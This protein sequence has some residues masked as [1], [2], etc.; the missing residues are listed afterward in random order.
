MLALFNEHNTWLGLQDFKGP[1]RFYGTVLMGAMTTTERQ[2][3]GTVAEG[4]IVYD[5]TLKVVMVYTGT[6][7]Q[8]MTTGA[9]AS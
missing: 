3:L 8:Y 6:G 9:E 1:V 7:W 4:T 2:A 5:S